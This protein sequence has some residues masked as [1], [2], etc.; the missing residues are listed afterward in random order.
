MQKEDG[1]I[2]QDYGTDCRNCVRYQK[3]GDVCLVEHG[4]K[5]FWEYCRDFDPQVVLPDYND[6]MKS[7]RMDQAL[8]RKKLKEKKEKEKKKKLKE[9]KEREVL[10]R[11][12]RIARL[13][14]RRERLKKNSLKKTPAKTIEKVPLAKGPGKKQSSLK[15]K[16]P[17]IQDQMK[18]A[19]ISDSGKTKPRKKI[20][21]DPA[22]NLNDKS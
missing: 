13:R 12:K 5:F 21:K 6:L 9:R 10:K 19:S 1:V 18:A 20:A 16:P 14:K 15:E 22:T 7:V 3:L 2:I 17:S 11:K 8:E 4:K